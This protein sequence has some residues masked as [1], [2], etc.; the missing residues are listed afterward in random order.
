MKGERVEGT[1]CQ[2]SDGLGS[3]H[4]ALLR[5]NHEGLV[6]D[7]EGHASGFCR[8]ELSNLQYQ[9]ETQKQQSMYRQLHGIHVRS[10]ARHAAWRSA[11]DL[12]HTTQPCVVNRSPSDQDSSNNHISLS[13]PL[14]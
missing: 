3:V 7:L 5:G 8:P 10:I 2:D 12:F 1:L 6:V 4:R 9:D 13:S 11:A 14:L